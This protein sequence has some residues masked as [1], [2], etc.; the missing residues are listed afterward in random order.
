MKVLITG[1]N[2]FIGRNLIKK[3]DYTIT[4]IGREDFDLTNRE[5]TNQWFADKQFDVVIHTAIVGGSRLKVDDGDIFYKNILMFYNL[6]ANQD[7]FKCLINFG[8][9]AE[10][11]FP[12]DPYGLSKNVIDK[13]VQQQPYF[14][15]LRI[16]GVFGEDE[17]DTRFIKANVKRYINKEPLQ[18]HQNKVMDFIYIDDLI[19]IIKEVIAKPI[20]YKHIDCCY[21]KSYSLQ[22]IAN[23]INELS[24]YNCPIKITQ[25]G[26]ANKYIGEFKLNSLNYIGLKQGIKKVYEALN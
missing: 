10:I 20:F 6:L 21:S 14:V 19:Q 18:I 13:I 25:D 26:L 9:G 4:S 22:E 3:L 17:W 7:K 12:T 11:G 2:G 23:I 5:E 8:S 16:F 15:N 1:K 24:D